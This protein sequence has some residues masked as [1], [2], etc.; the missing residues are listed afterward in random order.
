MMETQ[1]GRNDK[2]K[3]ILNIQRAG[4]YI[5]LIVITFLCLFSFYILVINS[6][7]SHPE[8]QSGFS[9][10][11]G[12]SLLTNFQHILNNTDIPILYGL[13]NSCIISASVA[14][15]TVYFSALTAYSI[16]AYNFRMKNLAYTFIL[17]VMMVPNQV[18]ALGFLQL[19]DQFHMMNTFWP[20][21]LPAIASPIVF[22]FMIQYMKSA[23]PLEIVEAARID[24]SSEFST[25]NRIVLPIL[26]P[27]MAVQA[28]FAF[29]TAWNNFFL[30]MLIL[31][32]P[33]NKTLPIMIAL[34]RSADYVKFDMGQIYMMI[35]VAIVPI[36]IVYVILSR[37]IVRGI[38]LGSVKG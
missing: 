25:F 8:I 34:L 37:Y 10:V 4:V 35:A 30:P 6:T 18:S 31:E 33:Q 19:M 12:N 14:I 20:L 3:A 21:I 9:F 5:A 32:S 26:K 7:H 23:L 27:A 38:T 16:Y 1:K 2:A 28:I 13:R 24:G 11:F 22:F 15:I 29:V 17:L 36:I